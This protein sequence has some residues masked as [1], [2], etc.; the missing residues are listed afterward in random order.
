MNVHSGPFHPPTPGLCGWRW[1]DSG[2]WL[3]CDDRAIPG[4]DQYEDLC[5]DHYITAAH[6]RAD[7]EAAALLAVAS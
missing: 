1:L 3:Y 4:V 6:A 7:A 2:V 5:A